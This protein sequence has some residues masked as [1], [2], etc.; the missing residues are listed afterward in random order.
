MPRCFMLCA[1]GAGISLAA[2]A[3]LKRPERLGNVRRFAQ[4][5]GLAFTVLLTSHGLAF[6]AR[7]ACGLWAKNAA[8]SANS[9]EPK[10]SVSSPTA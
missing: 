1:L 4:V 5:S 3:L 6:I 9:R 2:A 10:G 8:L 7:K